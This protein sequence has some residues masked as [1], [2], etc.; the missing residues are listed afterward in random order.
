MPPFFEEHKKNLG[1]T[2]GT[3]HPNTNQSILV[4]PI[5]STSTPEKNMKRALIP[6]CKIVSRTVVMSTTKSEI[7]LRWGLV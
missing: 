6:Y 3:P 5:L 2:G 7:E 1:K 4:W